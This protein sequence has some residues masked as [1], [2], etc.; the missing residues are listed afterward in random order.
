[1]PEVGE[2]RKGREIGR[3]NTPTTRYIWLSCPICNR[4]R[5]IELWW[6]KKATT[7][8][9][10][11]P[12]SNKIIRKKVP[13]ISPQIE[14]QISKLYLEGQLASTEIAEKLHIRLRLVTSAITRMNIARP[15]S[16]AIRLSFRKGRSFQPKG[17]DSPYWRGGR[18]CNQGYIRVY[19]PNHPRARAVNRLYVAE[20]ILVW[21]KT[22]NQYL[23]KDRVVHHLN[24]IKSD[25]RP[26]NLIAMPVGKHMKIIPEMAKKIRNLEVEN[27]QLRRAL[28]D[29]QAIMYLSEN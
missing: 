25:N 23:P 17:E 9:L 1:M 11:Q 27:R 16:E 28:E 7:P 26:D 22:H 24:G 10:C 3:F 8:G 21:E 4:S 13:S 19:A 18:Y 5:W 2:I 20:H 14:K 6:V 15:I 12:C 29:N